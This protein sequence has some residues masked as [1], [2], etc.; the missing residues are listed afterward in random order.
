MGL[1]FSPPGDLPDPGNEPTPLTP[2]ALADGFFTTST[3]WG[4]REQPRAQHRS[5]EVEVPTAALTSGQRTHCP[6]SP[7]EPAPYTKL[8]RLGHGSGPC[9]TAAR[10]MAVGCFP[11]AGRGQL[12]AGSHRRAQWVSVMETE[13]CDGHRGHALWRSQIWEAKRKGEAALGCDTITPT[14]KS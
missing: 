12:Q 8:M 6:L 13:P 9:V 3:A 11:K 5:G 7:C 2:P 10:E 1:P 4:A 14:I